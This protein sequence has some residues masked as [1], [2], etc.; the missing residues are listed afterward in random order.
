[1][2]DIDLSST[3]VFPSFY[4]DCELRS[5]VI[6]YLTRVRKVAFLTKPTLIS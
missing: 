6:Y 4:A 1:M 2:S 5:R 3:T